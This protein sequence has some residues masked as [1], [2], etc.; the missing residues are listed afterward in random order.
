MKFEREIPIS[1][2]AR[3]KK[4]RGGGAKKPHP[5]MGLGLNNVHYS[6]GVKNTNWQS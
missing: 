3:R 4:W 1:L 5:P 2:D 6:S